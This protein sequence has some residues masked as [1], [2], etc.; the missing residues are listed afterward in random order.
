MCTVILYTYQSITQNELTCNTIHDKSKYT[1]EM[2]QVVEQYKDRNITTG[3]KAG[4]TIDLLRSRGNHDHINGLERLV[5]KVQQET[6]T[7]KGT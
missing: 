7:N 5:N 1:H 3:G 2:K 6:V 4:T